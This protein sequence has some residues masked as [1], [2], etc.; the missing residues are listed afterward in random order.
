MCIVM[1]WDV[2]ISSSELSTSCGN[3]SEEQGYS[4][5]KGKGPARTAK[6]SKG[7]ASSTKS[8]PSRKKRKVEDKLN[9]EQTEELTSWILSSEEA[10][11]WQCSCDQLC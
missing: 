6:T 9:A 10:W 8:A 7:N 11:K 2:V 4:R 5:G 1:F 3:S